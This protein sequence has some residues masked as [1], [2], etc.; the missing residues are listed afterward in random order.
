MNKLIQ[1]EDQEVFTQQLR[2]VIREELA[3]LLF[4]INQK[5]EENKIL[6]RDDIM[7][8]YNI[9]VAT[10]W[11]RMQDK[12]IPYFKIGRRVYFYANEVKE[13]IKRN[14]I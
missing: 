4:K 3:E 7:K 5:P 11:H 14:Q 8:S 1:I 12:S 9:S 10:L 13:A 2:L 6:T